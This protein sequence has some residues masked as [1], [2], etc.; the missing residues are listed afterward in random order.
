[1]FVG[2]A[3]QDVLEPSEGLDVVELCGGDEGTYGCPSDTTAVRAREQ[4][5]LAT[6]RDGAN[7]AFDGVVVEFNTPVIKE[8]ADGAPTVRQGHCGAGCG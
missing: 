1:M 8:E 3:L 2:H 5:V 7:G 6:Q 4:M